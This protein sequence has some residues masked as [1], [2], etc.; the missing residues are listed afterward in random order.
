MSILSRFFGRRQ[1]PETRSAG[2]YT[3]L[4]ANAR[5]DMIAGRRGAAEATAAVQACIGLWEGGL[6]AADVTGT[7]AHPPATLALAARNL[8]LRGEWVAWIDGGRL[9]S[10]A[11][12][13]V[14]TLDG[15][16]RGNR[17]SHPGAGGGRRRTGMA[18]EGVPGA[19][20]PGPRA[21]W[22]GVPPLRRAGLTSELLATVEGVLGDVFAQAP[23]G[24]S[25]LPMPEM[26][27]DDSAA[28]SASFKGRRGSLLLRESVAVTS[29]GGAAPSTDWRPH[30]LTPEIKD[31]M[32]IESWDRA[33]DAGCAVF[34]CHPSLIAAGGQAAAIREAQRG[35]AVWTLAPLAKLIAAEAAAKLMAPIAI[36]PVRPVQAWDAGGRAR[37]ITA[38]VKG[39]AEAK[40]AGLSDAETA[41]ALRLVGWGDADG[42]G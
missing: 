21:P 31:A 40:A 1:A 10:A 6:S 19:L 5:A 8:A 12:W 13:D 39:I 37:A 2:A 14:S 35:L 28:L 30:G 25:V 4:L 17:Q 33:R 11:D 23:M 38:V 16:P 20:A 42:T 41:A 18:G 34:G 36:D 3:S 15:R 22:T 29:A 32:L 26:S 27:D 7:D 24:S 9:V